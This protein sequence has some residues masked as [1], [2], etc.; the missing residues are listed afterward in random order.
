MALTIFIKPTQRCYEAQIKKHMWKCLEKIVSTFQKYGIN[1]KQSSL[2]R[3]AACS[4]FQKTEIIG[5]FFF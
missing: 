4:F 3:K 5:V 1:I 2:I